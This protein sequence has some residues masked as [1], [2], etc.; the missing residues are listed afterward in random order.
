MTAFHNIFR[1][2]V[3]YTLIGS[4]VGAP[5][6]A[7]EPYPS[8]KVQAQLRLLN[9][10]TLSPR[11]QALVSERGKDGS[12][13]DRFQPRRSVI[14]SG[15][16]SGAKILV[17][18][19]VSSL[20][21]TLLER[22]RNL[23]ADIRFSSARYQ[24]LTLA[25]DAQSQLLELSRL[26]Q[27]L[28]VRE[29]EPWI[30]RA[31]TVSSRAPEALR[32]DAV[33]AEGN[34]G[35]GRVLG[36][37]SD[38]FARSADVRDA[39]TTPASGVA[40]SLQGSR[41]QD[42]GNLPASVTL[43][44]E[45]DAGSSDEGAAMAE[46]A[47]DIAPG[48]GISFHSAGNSQAA[49]AT[50]IDTL[51]DG[52]QANVIVDDIGFLLEP[53]YQDG[54]IAQAAADCVS[55]GIPFVSAI[56]N[57]GDRGYRQIYVDINPATD[58]APDSS[59]FTPSGAD[60][61]DWGG[62]DGFLEIQVPAAGEVIVVLQWNQPHASVNASNGAQI[63]L[64]LYATRQDSLAA[65]DPGNADFVDR[66]I[67]V[68]GNT[69]E[70]LGD[71]AEFL[72]LTADAGA[73]TTFY[74]A[75][76]HYI[77]SQGAI[78]Q[79][80]A[81]PLEFRLLLLG[82]LSNSEYAFNG[83]T[84]WGH[85]L[86]EGVVSVAAVP[87]W[88]A[89]DFAPARFGTPEIDP[90]PFSSKAGNT[91]IQFDRQGN[92]AP[93]VRFGP[94]LA[95]TDGNNTS[96]FGSDFNPDATPGFGEPDGA[97]NFF[98]SSAAAPN[99][100][101]VVVLLQQA[102]PE[103]SAR[104]ITDGLIATAID[105][106]GA[107]SAAGTDDVTGAGLIDARAAQTF[108]ANNPPQPASAEPAASGSG[109]GGG[110]CFIATAAYG[111]YWTKEVRL[112]REFRDKTLRQ[113]AAGRWLIDRYYQVSPPIAEA[114]AD[115]DALRAAVRYALTPVVWMLQLQPPWLAL[116]LLLTLV[117]VCHIAVLYWLKGAR[118]AP[119]RIAQGS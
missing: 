71:A 13:V 9:T 45:G 29:S 60:L 44:E 53:Y 3:A 114:I 20:D 69:E 10:Q 82:E 84:A 61:H 46:L 67:S 65:L 103:L 90:E 50:A 26:P 54:I 96:F 86:A 93:V 49:F 7:A 81:T 112:L 74:I 118:A 30:S 4:A 113:S 36:I 22:L 35:S 98:G 75:I 94:T 12:L 52:Q 59:P 55:R 102:F 91:S 66:S 119:A 48:V 88:E 57:D 106:R 15:A 95:G 25:L 117:A 16:Q 14:D 43:L 40:G 63:D 2:L 85:P 99:V 87:W 101:A 51:C 100:A 8:P 104:A 89:P 33:R 62:G 39:N 79:D 68:Q 105:V 5:D 18:V 19:N 107:R 47:Y 37:L 56:G 83:A 111:S 28:A 1:A 6:R 27:V 32:V 11:L 24:S 21:D 72:T 31:G 78:P 23:G 73:A 76:D 70:P 34:D 116:L 42:S 41:P 80:A 77:G 97:P 110:G 115:S 92:F 64:D 109:G 108:F 38:S 58:D 17:Q